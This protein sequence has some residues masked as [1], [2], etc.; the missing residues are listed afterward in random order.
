MIEARH[1]RVL[2]EVAR[3]GSYS[4]AAQ[5][6][7]YTQPAISQQMKALERSLGTVL[8]TRVGRTMRLT[9]AGEA[10]ARHAVAILAGVSAAEEEVAAIA[11]LRA[12]R[13]RLV[14][15][16]SGSSTLVPAALA[17]V[18]ERHPGVRISLVEAE[19]SD[20]ITLLR[21]G[22]CDVALTFAYPGVGDGSDGRGAPEK[23]DDLAQLPLLGDHLFALLPARHPSARRGRVRLADLAGERWI[24]GCARCRGQLVQACTDE[25]FTPDIAF[26]TDDYVAVQSL[27]AAGLGVALMPGLVLATVHHDALVARPVVPRIARQISAFT[28]PGLRD[29]PAVDAVLAA[30]GVAAGAL[31]PARTRSGEGRGSGSQARYDP[32]G[33]LATGTTR[34]RPPLRP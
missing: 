13:V 33:Q 31:R 19:P 26:A 7:G 15:F 29:V 14:S 30:L 18:S 16:P 9:E 28:L 20:A 25:G 34:V 12:G 17:R 21:A 8:V 27:V 24:G 32:S 22:E 23:L 10:L 11:G 5:A 1:L 6:L 3:C 4:A 2:R